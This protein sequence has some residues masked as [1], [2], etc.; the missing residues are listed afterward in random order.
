MKYICSRRDVKSQNLSS[1]ETTRTRCVWAR[2]ASGFS[3]ESGVR[4]GGEGNGQ[5]EALRGSVGDEERR[6]RRV[7]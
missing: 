3:H 2:Q 6:G 4:G 7:V 5:V 1:P